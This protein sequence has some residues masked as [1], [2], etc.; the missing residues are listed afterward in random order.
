MLDDILEYIG[1]D[2]EPRAA[3]GLPLPSM[4][5]ELFG[6]RETTLAPPSLPAPAAGRL[7]RP[8]LRRRN[9]TTALASSSSDLFAF[10]EEEEDKDKA[11]QQLQL[12][13]Q[14]QSPPP[15]PPRR[16]APAPT[17]QQQQQQQLQRGGG[18]RARTAELY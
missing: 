5:E 7:P 17:Q 9:I 4:Y 13:L 18:Q 14:L 11:A 12:Q 8:A 15:P 6:A 2:E 3:S 1:D 10:E 16:R